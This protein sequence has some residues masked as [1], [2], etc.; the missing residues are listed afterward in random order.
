[1]ERVLEGAKPA[2]RIWARVPLWK[3]AETL[4]KVAN[5]LREHKDVMADCLIKE[6]AKPAK[7]SVAEVKTSWPSLV[8]MCAY[9]YMY[10]CVYLY[11]QTNL[12]CFHQSMYAINI[13]PF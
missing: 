11:T 7:D 4:H 10:V 12:F 13:H 8:I 1:M 5:L 2:Q 6:V 3:R 9:T